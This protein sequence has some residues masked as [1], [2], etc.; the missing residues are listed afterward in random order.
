MQPKFFNVEY[1]GDQTP[2]FGP[3]LADY[4]CIFSSAMVGLPKNR[5][6]DLTAWAWD[7]AGSLIDEHVVR[8]CRTG[9][10]VTIDASQVF[11]AMMGRAGMIGIMCHARQGRTEKATETW[12]ARY[13]TTRDKLGGTVYAGNP[14]NLNYSERTGRRS[15]YRMCSQELLISPQWKTLSWHGNVSGN[16][17][18]G[19]PITARLFV[20]N[21]KGQR[22]EGPQQTI[23]PFGSVLIDLE[24]EMGDDL[25]RH[26]AETSGR[27]SYMMHSTDGGAVGYHFLQHR[28]SQELASDHTRPIL[29][30]L[31]RAYGWSP[32][33]QA[34]G[35]VN[36]LRSA[37]RVVKFRM[38]A[39]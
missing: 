38:Q 22:L 9:D 24:E 1:L 8:T 3:L 10:L 4:H 30:Y 12:A 7:D 19:K 32:E 29:H 33:T 31:N 25:R 36:F 2:W 16:P 27:G 23:A 17:D 35:P 21:Q 15:F 6:F 28:S 34:R 26:L 37:A 13:I 18:Y 14:L 5:E 20:F 11:P 39:N